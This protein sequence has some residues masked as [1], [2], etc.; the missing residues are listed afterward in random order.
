M[1]QRELREIGYRKHYY[2]PNFSDNERQCFNCKYG[3]LIQTE[4]EKVQCTRWNMVVEEDDV[5]D[6]F[7]FAMFWAFN[8][9]DEDRERR[10]IKLENAK[11]NSQEGCYIATAVYGGYDQPE[12][13]ILRRFRDEV[14]RSTFIGRL[15]VKIYYFISSGLAKRLRKG[16]W[17]NE[18]IKRLLDKFVRKLENGNTK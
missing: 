15:S 14:L 18:T 6:Y 9:M 3:K 11:K 13:M 1:D 17:I 16:S 5:C 10:R 8:C 12:V 7:D 2:G 4:R